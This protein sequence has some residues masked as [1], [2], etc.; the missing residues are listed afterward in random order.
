[1]EDRKAQLSSTLLRM[2]PYVHERVIESDRTAFA[3]RGLIS[4]EQLSRFEGNE[5]ATAALTDVS[6]LTK[7]LLLNGES[8]RW[9]FMLEG[10]A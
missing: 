5:E 9:P 4:R 2:F 10:L 1:M 6:E 3:R 8:S 7:G